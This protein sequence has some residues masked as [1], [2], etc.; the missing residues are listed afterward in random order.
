MKR[1][2]NSRRKREIE[3]RKKVI[4][5]AAREVFSKKGYDGTTIDEVAEKAE[6]AKATLYKFF[7]TKEELYLGVVEDVFRE[8]N[9]IA[10]VSMNGGGTARE[11]FSMFVDRLVEHFMEHSDFLRLLMREF[12][13]INTTGWKESQHYK[14]HMELNNILARE[15]DVA[16]KNGEVRKVDTLRVAQVFNHMVY[17]YHLNNLFY[18]HDKKLK[19]KAVEFLVSIFFDGISNKVD[20]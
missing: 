13:K 11:K 1:L 12:S 20:S 4:I 9:E 7:P 19:K 17:A 15:L 18:E 3:F 14:I 2:Q 10:R 8:I 16:V 6:L 5:E